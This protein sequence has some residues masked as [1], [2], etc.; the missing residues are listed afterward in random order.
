MLAA[1]IAHESVHLN[2][3]SDLQEELRATIAEIKQWDKNPHLN[4][5]H[6]L[7]LRLNNLSQLYENGGPAA[8]RKKIKDNEA[9]ERL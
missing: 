1:L 2:A 4:S 6:P 7:V 8:I 3:K 5:E 9:Y